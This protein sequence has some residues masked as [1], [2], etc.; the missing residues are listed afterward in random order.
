MK[1]AKGYL[2]PKQGDVSRFITV[3]DIGADDGLVKTSK[4]MMDIQNTSTECTY[5]HACMHPCTH[6]HTK[7]L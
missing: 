4:Y 1:N 3:D 7:V 2:K 6:M 5:T